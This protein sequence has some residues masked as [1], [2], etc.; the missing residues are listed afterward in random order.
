[1]PRRIRPNLAILLLTFSFTLL[2]APRAYSVD[3]R[4]FDEF[5]Y[6]YPYAKYRS[7]TSYAG[8]TA[9]NKQQCFLQVSHIAKNGETPFGHVFGVLYIKGVDGNQTFTISGAA[10]QLSDRLVSINFD[11]HGSRLS[12]QPNNRSRLHLLEGHMADERVRTKNGN[13]YRIWRLVVKL[14]N[15][16][17]GGQKDEVRYLTFILNDSL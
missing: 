1:M 3:Y 16:K 10:V 13:S 15:C 11:L 5:K 14:T 7:L 9:D 12:K 4:D 8:A 6:I 2:L 17:F